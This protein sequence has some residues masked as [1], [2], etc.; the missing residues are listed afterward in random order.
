[1]LHTSSLIKAKAQM[2]EVNVAIRPFV[3]T[4]FETDKPWHAKMFQAYQLQFRACL[5]L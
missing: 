5:V 4:N 1:M 2:N 3:A